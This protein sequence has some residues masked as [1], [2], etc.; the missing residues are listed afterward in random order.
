M[1]SFRL[2]HAARDEIRPVLTDQTEQ[3]HR[4]AGALYTKIPKFV[5]ND[6]SYWPSSPASPLPCLSCAFFKF[7]MAT[8]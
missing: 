6:G 5:N 7:A 8:G 4:R 3:P 1:T 2:L